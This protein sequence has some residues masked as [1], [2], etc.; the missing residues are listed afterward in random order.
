MAEY[1]WLL[2]YYNLFLIIIYGAN[3]MGIFVQICTFFFVFRTSSRKLPIRKI[4]WLGIQK[5][6]QLSE[7][8][9]ELD[10]LSFGLFEK[11]WKFEVRTIFSIES[12][13]LSPSAEPEA[14]QQ[15]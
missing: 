13:S 15:Q 8:D 10:F 3:E 4:Q 2:Y 11:I 1:S 9:E 7:V 6:E 5:L 14:Q 12:S